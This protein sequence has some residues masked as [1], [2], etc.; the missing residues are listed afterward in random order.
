[1]RLEGIK[2]DKSVYEILDPIIELG[3]PLYL[4]DQKGKGKIKKNK[5]RQV[6]SQG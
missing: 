1:M 2:Q 5:K 4:K 6:F 3:M